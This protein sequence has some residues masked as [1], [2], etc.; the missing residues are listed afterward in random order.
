MSG[1]TAKKKIIFLSTNF[2]SPMKNKNT[3]VRLGEWDQSSDEDCDENNCSEPVV[4]VPVVDR[5]PH[6]NYVPTSKAQENDIA[7][8][9]L[10]HS[11][12]FTDWVK[13]ICLPIAPSTRNINYDEYV[14]VV[15]GWGKTE[16]FSNESIFCAPVLLCVHVFFS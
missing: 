11:V 3:A 5:I 6:E 4:D 15:A 13:P 1:E 8:L 7:L 16:V 10:G 9:R 14:F 2:R 12:R